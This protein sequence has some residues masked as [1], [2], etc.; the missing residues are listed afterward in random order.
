MN[1]KIF[2]TIIGIFY[3]VLGLTGIIVNIRAGT[4][5]NLV[6]FCNHASI[7]LGIAFLFRSSFWVTAEINIGLIPQLL[8]SID[9]LG[10]L[11]FDKFVFG[12]TDYMFSPHFGKIFFILSWNHVFMMPIA[13]IGLY[14]LKA[15]KDAWKGSFIHGLLLIPLS[16]IFA[17][18]MNLNCMHESCV[19][20]IPTTQFYNL[21][22]PPIMLIGI[23]IPTQLLIYWG[24][25]KIK[26]AF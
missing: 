3:I 25:K 18:G 8:F 9:F 24:Y 22:W 5:Y 16:Y 17:N 7:I 23:I 12:F 4:S 19:P 20:F 2:L 26:K 21:Y 13:L 1:K 15:R 10:K 11:I 14:F 6:W